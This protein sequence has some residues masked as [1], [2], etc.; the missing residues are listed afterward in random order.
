MIGIWFSRLSLVTFAIP[1]F[2]NG[3]R[4]DDSKTEES[5]W[6]ILK[7]YF[8]SNVIEINAIVWHGSKDRVSVA[9][10]ECDCFL[11]LMSDELENFYDSV[12]LHHPCLN[13]LPVAL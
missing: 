10:T 12:H 7:F 9:H 11:H 8:P 2:R 13:K 6:K 5:D 3:R 4:N 1:D